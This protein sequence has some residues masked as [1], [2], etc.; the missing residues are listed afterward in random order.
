DRLAGGNFARTQL[1]LL[2]VTPHPDLTRQRI[3]QGLDRTP[4]TANRVTF[5]HLG[6]EHEKRDD[7]RGEKL[8][9]AQRGNERNGHG[10]FHRHAPLA[11]VLPRLFENGESTDK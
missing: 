1:T 11:K 8:P 2:A 7:E 6:E 3:D 5:D 4:P 9:D 10:E